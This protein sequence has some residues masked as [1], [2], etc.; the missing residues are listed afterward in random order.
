MAS[1]RT[2][3]AG[4]DIGAFELGET[5]DLALTASVSNYLPGPG[6]PLTYTLVIANLGP[7][8]AMT[9]T[10][11]DELPTAAAFVDATID[12]GACAYSSQ[13]T[14]SL[15]ILTATQTA[16]ATVVITLPAGS[17]VIT[18]TA[19]VSATTPDLNL[20]NNTAV[21]VLGVRTPIHVIQGAGHTSPLVGKPV[22]TGGIVTAVRNNGF[23]LQEPNGDGDN[24]TSEAIFVYTGGSPTTTVGDELVVSGQVTEFQ[25]GSPSE[26]NLTITELTAPS[27]LALSAGNALPAPVVRGSGGRVPP[28]TVIEDDDL[29][30]FDP[31]A[32]GLDFDESLEAMR[33][34]IDDAVVVG[35]SNR[36]GEIWVLADNGAGTGPR[37]VGRHPCDGK[38]LQPR[39]LP[40]RRHALSAERLAGC[41]RGRAFHRSS[42]RRRR[43]QL[44]QL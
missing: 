21:I 23:Y 9:V 19:I 35:P 6:G 17:G 13:V 16:T 24:A 3:G 12:G 42:G 15:N 32:D 18:S 44:R 30:V 36:F 1:R 7:S 38:R 10:F 22:T 40:A 20:A 4:C 26:Q 41:Q 39:A 5:A 28:S 2:E 29:T 33:V 31:S 11:T 25:P 8:T 14:C 43:L 34:Q 27:Y 37:T